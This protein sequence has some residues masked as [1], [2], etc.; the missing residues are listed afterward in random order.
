MSM[1]RTT[2]REVKPQ[3]VKSAIKVLTRGAY[4]VTKDAYWGLNWLTWNHPP[5]H[6]SLLIAMGDAYLERYIIWPGN[7]ALE[8]VHPATKRSMPIPLEPL[9]FV[10]L[11]TSVISMPTVVTRMYPRYR[12][13]G[14]D[15]L[16]GDMRGAYE[17]DELQAVIS[18]CRA[19][20]ESR[21]NLESLAPH[22]RSL[23]WDSLLKLALLSQEYNVDWAIAAMDWRDDC[24]TVH[25]TPE[26][27]TISAE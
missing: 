2:L 8:G 15:R 26:E 6:H 27:S 21:D 11:L 19:L 9:E 18:L 12:L 7:A 20:G 23:T 17:E 4:N 22:W 16:L 13:P 25:R 24:T 10:D 5:Q 1:Y 14:G 3:P